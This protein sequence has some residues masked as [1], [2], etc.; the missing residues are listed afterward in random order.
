MEILTAAAEIHDG[1]YVDPGQF[2]RIARYHGKRKLTAED[3]EKY[4]APISFIRHLEESKG[5]RLTREEE[6]TARDMYNHGERAL[7]DIN[8]LWIS[9][10]VEARLLIR[11][12]QF[13][14]ELDK[15]IGAYRDR[16]T[17]PEEDLRLLLAVIFT[18][19]IF[20]N[21]NNKEKMGLFR[22]GRSTETF[23]ETFEFLEAS[24]E[25]EGL[26]D[27]RPL[28]AL[29]AMIE[30]KNRLLFGVVTEARESD[31]ADEEV[32]EFTHRA[33]SSGAR[34]GGPRNIMS[35]SDNEILSLIAPENAE[36]AK[37]TKNVLAYA[38]FMAERLGSFNQEMRRLLHFTVLAHDVGGVLG[39]E[40]REAAESGLISLAKVNDI[41]YIGRDP[42][43][44]LTEFDSKD[45]PLTLKQRQSVN[46]MDHARN[47]A[48]VL[49]AAGIEV[50][51]AIE[52]LI[53]NHMRWPLV[54]SAI[55]G[56]H[57]SP[58]K[59]AELLEAAACFM[60]GDSF[61]FG[62]NNYKRRGLEE[63]RRFESPEQT[64]SFI[65]RCLKESGFPD[66]LRQRVETVFGELVGEDGMIQDEGFA[67]LIERSRMPLEEF[68]RLDMTGHTGPGGDF[69]SS[70]SGNIPFVV[71]ED[72][73]AMSVLAADR[74][75]ETLR[76]KPDAVIGLSSGNTPIGMYEELERRRLQGELD[77]VD[78]SKATFVQPDNFLLSPAE[79]DKGYGGYLRRRFFE[80]F[81]IRKDQIKL[82]ELKEGQTPQRCA[83]EYE[84][85]LKRNPID[86]LI[87]GISPIYSADGLY[88]G[89]HIGFNEP[90]S[91]R[92]TLTRLVRLTY[93]TLR[94][95]APEFGGGIDRVPK[96][97]FTI[98]IDT[99]LR[100]GEILLL[101][102]GEEKADAVKAVIEGDVTPLIPGTFLQEHGNALVI[103]DREAA[104]NLDLP[105]EVVSV[106]TDA[107]ARASSS[108]IFKTALTGAAI[109]LLPIAFLWGGAFMLG[110][111]AEPSKVLLEPNP[112]VRA[113]DTAGFTGPEWYFEAQAP[114]GEARDELRPS[115]D[116]GDAH[117]DEPAPSGSGGFLSNIGVNLPWIN[118]GLDIGKDPNLEHI[119]FSSEEGRR[120][121]DERFGAFEKAGVK[122][123]RVFLFGNF[124]PGI[125]YDRD[126][127]MIFGPK[128]YEDMD[129]LLEEAAGHG[130]R[131]I[132]VILNHDLTDGVAGGQGEQAHWFKDPH[133]RGML[134]VLLKG[135]I[136]R[137]ADNPNIAMWDVMNEPRVVKDARESRQADV[138]DFTT[139]RRF[140]LNMA[141]YIHS[142]G[143]RVSVS[144]IG[145]NDFRDNW[146]DMQSRFD[147]IDMHFYGTSKELAALPA[148]ADLSSRPVRIGEIGIR[149]AAGSPVSL[150]SQNMQRIF[151][152]LKS[153]GYT[154]VTF[155]QDGNYMINLDG[156]NQA[157]REAA[158]SGD[159][160]TR[161][162]SS[163]T[164]V[165]C[166]I[167]QDNSRAIELFGEDPVAMVTGWRMLEEGFSR[168]L[169]T[170]NEGNKWV[171]RMGGNGRAEIIMRNIISYYQ[172]RGYFDKI[173]LVDGSFGYIDQKGYIAFLEPYRDD[174]HDMRREDVPFEVKVQLSILDEL[175]G[176][177]IHSKYQNQIMRDD[178]GN[179][180]PIALGW[181]HLGEK[182]VFDSASC[183]PCEF[184]DA[185]KSHGRDRR[186]YEEEA[187]RWQDVNLEELI[188]VLAA[189]GLSEEEAA[190]Y[191]AHC[192]GRQKA[193]A[194][195]IHA[196]LDSTESWFGDYFDKLRR[197]A[198][199]RANIVLGVTLNASRD[200]RA[201]GNASFLAGLKGLRRIFGGEP[202][203]FEDQYRDAAE[204]MNIKSEP[205]FSA[206]RRSFHLKKLVGD[207]GRVYEINLASPATRELFA[208][209]DSVVYRMVR[210]FR[211]EYVSCHLSAPVEERE[212]GTSQRP[213]EVPLSP[214][215]GRD[216]VLRRFVEN[217]NI[218]Q[219]NLKK[220]GYDKPVLVEQLDYQ[221]SGAYEYITD[222]DF[223]FEVLKG[224]GAHLLVDCSHMIV[225]AKNRHIDDPGHDFMEYI[226]RIINDDTIGLV[227]EV[228][229]TVPEYAARGPYALDTHRYLY[230][231]CPESLD[232]EKV[233]IYILELRAKNGI[234]EP[235]AVNFET[236]ME[237]AAAEVA[238]FS[239][240]INREFGV[241][242]IRRD[243]SSGMR[244]S[245]VRFVEPD[246][247]AYMQAE[248]GRDI[249]LK[250][251]AEEATM[252]RAFPGGV[253]I[254]A[255]T[256]AAGVWQTVDLQQS[257]TDPN[258]WEAVIPCLTLKD[259]SL[260]VFVAPSGSRDNEKAR[261]YI[262]NEYGEKYITGIVSVESAMPI[263]EQ[264][265]REF[266]EARRDLAL[267][268]LANPGRR[269][270]SEDKFYNS[271]IRLIRLMSALSMASKN[272]SQLDRL[273]L[274]VTRVIREASGFNLYAIM[275]GEGRP[276]IANR[277][278]EGQLKGMAR[279]DERAPD[280][281]GAK[282]FHVV[283][284][285][286]TGRVKMME[287]RFVPPVGEML[288]TLKRALRG[289]VLPGENSRVFYIEDR[290]KR[291]M[292]P[293]NDVPSI[294]R[295]VS[296]QAWEEDV[297]RAGGY[298]R[299]RVREKE[300]RLIAS[301]PQDL[302][303]HYR[304]YSLDNW[305]DT[306]RGY[307]LRRDAAALF[308]NDW[309]DSLALA[310]G[311]ERIKRFQDF[312][313]GE[314][315][316]MS[317]N[318]QLYGRLSA[319]SAIADYYAHEPKNNFA[320]VFTFLD[321]DIERYLE[322]EDFAGKE[323]LFAAM[324]KVGRPLLISRKALLSSSIGKG[325]TP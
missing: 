259:F 79:K 109:S 285:D 13:P 322:R 38:N 250:I 215:L 238:A 168:R 270:E 256:D 153:K 5:E 200:P 292:D 320:G 45:V 83:E 305:Q 19:D 224:T 293:A 283:G 159:H 184:P 183:E 110:A 99:I 49:D 228:H 240:M 127:R 126:G 145:A 176:S 111:E 65:L 105:Y 296:A 151:A 118:Y 178:H 139:L 275:A 185:F 4:P 94:K 78:F 150:T 55:N 34:A 154:G 272:V 160:Q 157:V 251:Y 173:H 192:A 138:V 268:S 236:D 107:P 98:G 84:A 219:A 89:G 186:A 315:A 155:W 47:S 304:V 181:L 76:N 319:F 37:H 134:L 15:I 212:F 148:A 244:E 124:A 119:G 317:V 95:S 142:R 297:A 323:D 115:P 295:C 14:S 226:R 1:A 233:L 41:G 128:V 231:E 12:H 100:A 197:E 46:L 156:L 309:V 36:L 177:H 188:P 222:P 30:N 223:I 209:E 80:P 311:Y 87:L 42:A 90:F 20:E 129:A 103:L 281:D 121:L 146:K 117:E 263:M 96:Y 120:A 141:D 280:V 324:R 70:S 59:K 191:I 189:S 123:T 102:S 81:G 162:S 249:P 50:P 75:I 255:E 28:E 218:L 302:N 199:D 35:L 152:F 91:I 147:E 144:C 71:A 11:C 220:A 10:P 92:R 67:A 86:L 213:Y 257:G 2:E 202:P 221:P 282:R 88:Q 258:L 211:P 291:L 229:V 149:N 299:A 54:V 27:R 208:D 287:K 3:R 248:Y 237:G 93:P 241:K 8:A 116:A 43:D 51:H 66:D 260:G 33:S 210:E 172:A 131:V 273:L 175:F 125:T 132:P 161:P 247:K 140:V 179:V 198:L 230:T 130:I 163:G 180:Y 48:K 68:A 303:T 24:Y 31:I 190:S 227:R 21:G 277:F 253:S 193:L 74:L 306:G 294:E 269:Q 18:A 266:I 274:T 225:A 158:S 85:F 26:S 242:G 104:G 182:A 234:T 298:G 166:P 25:R 318:A 63:Y 243:S 101:A 77:G 113:G 7:R 312:V 114:V 310:L 164:E 301:D 206:Q 82:L 307:R 23:T 290:E 29:A 314:T 56:S 313:E 69:R 143:G 112:I 254:T 16:L 276:Y 108:G 239:G 321:S 174:F 61:E 165:K 57:L 40:E 135:F 201:A 195:R 17:I 97:A 187:A 196:A 52:I 194:G 122:M 278:F 170:D 133:Q 171:L 106:D 271:T 22:Q 245:P 53:A 204:R 64:V 214:L 235:L 72:Y 217:I 6:N 261:K 279:S 246:N 288:M 9:L 232:V 207:D 62:N 264:A 169:V 286:G 300:W 265:L 32:E 308:L 44:V 39:D 267:Y 252:K 216:E 325:F 316:I 60:I 136:A 73:R 203:L 58:A 167:Y 262:L 284:I 289:L 137:Y 205:L